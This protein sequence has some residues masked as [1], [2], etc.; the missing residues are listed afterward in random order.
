MQPTEDRAG[1]RWRF[2]VALA[3][4]A[5]GALSAGAE[6]SAVE[7]PKRLTVVLWGSVAIAGLAVAVA[8]GL[9]GWRERRARAKAVQ[10]RQRAEQGRAMDAGRGVAGR[11]EPGSHFT[12]RDAALRDLVGWLAN[13][14]GA[15]PA[16][17]VV[18]GGPGSGKSALLGRLLLVASR[19]P[20]RLSDGVKVQQEPQPRN[21]IDAF[22]DASRRQVEEITAEVAGRTGVGASSADE[23]VDALV[24]KGR[25]MVLV[26]DGL[27][28]A[29]RPRQLVRDLI[30]PLA[31]EGGPLG[32][33]LLVGARPNLL[34]LFRAA[35]QVDLDSPDYF[36]KADLADYVL[37]LLLEDRSTGPS[38]YREDPDIAARVAAAVADRAGRSFL[39]AQLI[40]RSLVQAPAVDVTVPEWW[41]AFPATVDEA[42]DDYLGRFGD[43]E[44]RVRGLLL[45]LAYSEGP[46][47]AEDEL[48]VALAR[49]LRAGGDPEPDV[50][51]L[52]STPARDLLQATENDGMRTYR[53]FHQALAEHLQRTASLSTAEVHRRFTATLEASVP[54]S[55][56][57]A[58]N[59]LAA[60]RY[61]RAHLAAHARACK[62]LDEFLED[63]LYLVA[64]DPGLLLG[65]LPAATTERARTAERLL[66]RLGARLRRQPTTER[67][68]VLELGARQLR[69][70]FAPVDLLEPMPTSADL[71]VLAR[72]QSHGEAWNVPSRRLEPDGSLGMQPLDPCLVTCSS[73]SRAAR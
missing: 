61:V 27:D 62:R 9:V 25:P 39:I 71:C 7:R 51:W 73:R 20:R 48:W 15:E 41:Q 56:R 17:C 22:V 44:P 55:A 6:L 38:P 65:A 40:A 43:D 42:M 4:A 29:N 11:L 63:P 28:E 68:A 45:P 64:A 53:L 54:R 24:R 49:G 36:S 3:A 35:R 16:V 52:L 67:A 37:G 34:P 19:W 26:I 5:V 50:S 60:H 70:R 30:R 23:L 57:G 72:R 14:T 13:E 12:G 2:G 10:A 21:G 8:E 69:R 32:I 47:L 33:R 18:T 66:W 46:G 1:R 31:R 59:W 58:R